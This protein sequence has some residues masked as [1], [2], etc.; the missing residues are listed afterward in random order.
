MLKKNESAYSAST[1]AALLS[2]GLNSTLGASLAAS[3]GM[4]TA[5][6]PYRWMLPDDPS[7]INGVANMYT[8]MDKMSDIYTGYTIM[9]AVVLLLLMIRL[10][11]YVSFQPRLAIVSGTLARMVPDLCHYTV[12]FVIMACMFAMILTTVFGY[13]VESVSTFPDALSLLV[14]YIIVKKGKANVRSIGIH[15]RFWPR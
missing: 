2:S 9:Q 10:I 7:G 8:T 4:P 11:H 6:Q 15:V 3:G 13:R 12:V 1:Y 14:K 5:G